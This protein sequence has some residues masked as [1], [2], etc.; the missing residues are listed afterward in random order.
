M[1][2]FKSKKQQTIKSRVLKVQ[3]ILGDVSFDS[4]KYDSLGF[5]CSSEPK[6]KPVSSSQNAENLQFISIHGNWNSRPTV[7]GN[8][9]FNQKSHVSIEQSNANTF[10][11]PY[12]VAKQTDPKSKGKHFLFLENLIASSK[13]ESDISHSEQ[14]K[15]E[16][17]KL[18]YCG[19]SFD[20]PLTG[21]Y[22]QKLEGVSRGFFTY[23]QVVGVGFRV[24]L[25][26]DILT[27]KLGFSH[28][29]K[30]RLPESVK[31][32]LPEP[33]LICLYGLDKNQ[34]TQI[35]AKIQQ[36]KPPSPYKGKGIKL[37]DT[38]IRLKAG[39]KKS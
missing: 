24:F 2:R 3:G 27:F 36:I 7:K 21:L 10:P 12:D 39:K 37:L 1:I 9:Y 38:Q 13:T 30:V 22:S 4:K 19:N 16:P 25:V 18:S 14:K 11:Y 35:A 17:G 15:S 33:T 31:V 8:F 26:Q 20:C 5:Y 29:V 6:S 28:F 23:L 34:V 32:F